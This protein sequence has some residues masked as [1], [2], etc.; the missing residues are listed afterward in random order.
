MNEKTQRDQMQTT[1]ILQKFRETA[2][3]ITTFANW[4]FPSMGVPQN[5]WFIGENTNLKWMIWGYLHLWKPSNKFTAVLMPPTRTR[6][7]CGA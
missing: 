6:P 5:R 4:G 3:A 1:F 2:K 7:I